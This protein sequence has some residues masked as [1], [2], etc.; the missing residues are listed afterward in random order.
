M[1]LTVN[2]NVSSLN[3][4][5]NLT[6]SGEGLATSM[7]RLSSG[8]R[9]NSA[10]DD[11]AGLQISNRLTSQINGLSVA[12]RNAND[13]ISMAQTAEGAMS[14]STNILQRMR[15]LALQAAN[16]SNSTEDRE[17]LQKEV[18]AL[19]VELTRIADTTS[20]GGQQLLD[21]SYG[22]KAFQVGAN[23]NETIN[24][25]LSSVAADKIGSNQVNLQGATVGLGEAI[26]GTTAG[27]NSGVGVGSYTISGREDASVAVGAGATAEEIASS[28]NSY[29]S[30]T[31]V[32]AQAR[33]EA[34]IDFTSA[35]TSVDDGESISFELNG[36]K[37]SFVGTGSSEND[38]QAMAEAIN[39][40]TDEHN[41]TAT[42]ENGVLSISN[43]TGDDLVLENVTESDNTTSSISLDVTGVSY[44]GDLNDTTI[45]VTAGNSVLV[46][47]TVQL[48]SAEVFSAK[49]SVD[50]LAA[51]ITEEFSTLANV[52]SIDVSDQQGSQEALSIIDNAIAS[53]DS[54]RAG[55]GAVQN[56]FNHT[57]SNLANI[58]ENVSASR[59]RI[60]D[61]DFATETA[62]MT[63]NQ[64]LQQAGTSILSQANQVP[65]AAISLLGG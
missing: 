18:S 7:E 56:R 48:N 50:T 3:A 47:G 9:I 19:Q 8:M 29:T 64:I 5:R 4:Q 61:T 10:K 30:S 24:V 38:K 60:Q 52:E 25:S 45:A 13:G 2:T 57:I 12:Q 33:S 43:N 23:A 44:D 27:T 1:A 32:T 63:K 15:E 28:I 20:F 65:Q 39:A 51:T 37:V 16:G 54:Q 35:T 22:S 59:S 11:A 46:S 34:Q 62:E 6:K 31:G 41:V 55:L 17:A 14:E 49:G 21:G 36:E 42:I 58:S 40:K 53:I 26:A